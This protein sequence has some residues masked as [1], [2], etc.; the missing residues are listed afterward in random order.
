VY[1][2]IIEEVLR[3]LREWCSDEL[4]FSSIISRAFGITED[5]ALS[6]LRT[7]VISGS[8][9][10]SPLLLDDAAMAGAKGGY[11]NSAE[12]GGEWIVLN[13]T[14]LQ[15]AS[16]T[17]VKAVVL[18]EIGHA[19]D[20]RLHQSRDSPGDEGEV[21]SALI[22]GLS[23]SS[24]A[25]I[26]NDHQWILLNGS[27]VRMEASSA[28]PVNLSE[29]DR[30]GGGYI[31]NGSSAYDYSGFSVSSAGDV[32]GDGLDDLIIG[33]PSKGT[34]VGR[35][36]GNSYVVFGKSTKDPIDLSEVAAG[37]GGYVIVGQSA[38]D[39]SG[40]SV[41]GLGDVNGDGLAD[42]FVGAPFSDP[43]GGR[44]AGR[45]YVVFGQRITNTVFLS[46]VAAGSGGFVINGQSA[47]D[48]SGRSISGAGDVNGDG[49]S[50]FIVGAPFSDSTSGSQSGRSYVVFGKS[51]TD[52]IDLSAVS[53]GF[54]GFVINAERPYDYSGFSVSGAGD[55]N[56]DGFADLVV[57]SPWSRASNGLRN[58]RSYVVF[59][60]ESPTS[61]DLS[62]VSQGNGGF[63]IDGSQRFSYSGMSVSSAGDVNG[64]GL[65][66][67]LVGAQLGDTATAYNGGRTYVVFGKSSTAPLALSD[68]EAGRGGGFVVDG[69]AREDR[70][71]NSV[72]SAGDINGDGLGD[73][74]IGAFK[75]NTSRLDI[76][77]SYVVF[78]KA[79]AAPVILSSLVATNSGFII[80]GQSS[81]DYSGSSVS[82]AGDVNG[83][84]LADLAVGAFGGNPQEGWVNGKNPSTGFRAGRTYVIFGATSGAFSNTFIDRMGT[85]ESDIIIGTGASETFVGNYGDDTIVGNGGAD[86]LLG[87]SGND[88]LHLTSTNLIAL[89][90]P[91]GAGG[92]ANQLARLDG[93]AGFDT[94]VLDGS[95]LSFNLDSVANQRAAYSSYS[96]RLNSIEAFDLTGSGANSLSLGLSDIR[97]IVDFN[98][99]NSQTSL[100]LGFASGSFSLPVFQDRRQSV[101]TG[102]AGDSL[103]V[104]DGLWSNVGTL[105]GTGR[106]AGSTFE[107]WNGSTEPLQLIVNQLISSK[108]PSL[109]PLP[110]ISLAVSSAAV[111]EDGSSNL[112]YTFSRSGDTTNPL[113]VNYA[114]GGSATNGSDYALIPASLTFAAGA[115]TAT[116][117]V[118]PI[119]D[120]I[121]EPDET[122]SLSLVARDAYTIGTTGSVS[123]TIVN[124]DN[125]T[126]SINDVAIVE[127][128]LGTRL[129]VF[130]VSLS[131]AVAGGAAVAFATA[132]GTASAGSDYVANSGLLNFTG[133]AGEL[134]TIAV[135]INGDTLFEPDESF[136]LNLSSPTNGVT[137]AK[138]QGSGT[139][140]NDDVPP[141]PV[142]SLAVSSAAVTEDGSSNLIYTFSRSGDTTNPLSVNYAIGGS[143]TNGSDYALIPAS[144]TFA[145]GARTATVIVDPI[146]D[147]IVEPDETVSLSLVARDAYTIGTTGSV[148]GTIVDILPTISAS[149]IVAGSGGFVINGELKNDFFGFNVASL[150]DVNA[151]GYAD[152]IISAHLDSLASGRFG[153]RS[154]VVFG[155]NTNQAVD[156]SE[157]I[158]GRGG[159]VVNGQSGGDQAGISVAGVGDVN[160]DGFA[161]FIVGA[162]LSDPATGSN[163]GR[164]YVVFGKSFSDAIE[165]STVAAGIGGFVINGQSADDRSGISVAGAGDVNGDGLAD[166]IVGAYLSDTATG[167]NAGRSYVVFGKTSTEATSLSDVA[168]GRGGFAINGQSPADKSG[169]SVAG[170]GDVNGDGLADVIIGAHLSDPASID[171][172]G[173]SYVVFGKTSNEAI[174]LASV[175][176]GRGGLV[177]NGGSSQ[178]YSGYSI[179]SAGDVNGDGFADLI[180][181]A[182]K[183]NVL[184]LRSGRSFVVFGKTATSAID[185]SAI[186]RGGGGGF[187]INGVSSFDYSGLSVASAGDINGDGLADVI[188]GAVGRNTSVGYG[189]GRSYVVFGKVS[190]DPVNLSDMETGKGGL[191]LIIDGLRA[192][193][194]SGKSVSSAGDVN[195]DGLSDL[196]VGAASYDP[197]PD[198][199]GG[200]AYVILG[201]TSGAFTATAVDRSGTAENDTIIGTSEAETFVG[202]DGDDNIIGNGGADVLLGGNGNDRFH[203]KGSNLVALSNPFG[204]GGN[205][206]Q[207]SRV[208]GGFGFD[209]IVLDGSGLSFNVATVA[210]QSTPSTL[211]SSRLNSIE[212]FDLSGSGSN[213][214]SVGLGDLRDLVGFNWLNSTSAASLGITS[215]SFLIPANQHRRQLLVTGDVGDRFTVIDGL[216]SNIGTLNGANSFAGSRFNVWNS[217][218]GSAQLLVNSSIG[219]SFI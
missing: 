167:I 53:A 99:L 127:G 154:Y 135:T 163:A 47:G 8:F 176:A 189:A 107:V 180:V 149:T 3:D 15:T 103:I 9:I 104:K 197:T 20:Y 100:S 42:L 218:D 59:G 188:V 122:V 115:R 209:T 124:D 117:I 84:G 162:H 74:I 164:S 56:G 83:D 109:I 102:D 202:H 87:G 110:V 148:S 92:N 35:D 19:I 205:A 161:D 98:W 185:L 157:V 41:A 105:L 196:I 130:T 152:L 160:G 39:R 101:I 165:L 118:D 64:D 106:F 26:E 150:G 116:V 131:H 97:N 67:I 146:A 73:I 216:W 58:G 93:G 75:A 40:F 69:E 77:K 169:F 201:S 213:S 155:K 121:V 2:G 111:T 192:F 90:H 89:A 71:G 33:A 28:I 182:P 65:A 23:P 79:S 108:I 112:I 153:G 46:S 168:M 136:F 142:I 193:D 88:R 63:V 36:A 21:F 57:G 187:V 208:D 125:A 48:Q 212:A 94:I 55:V 81:F 166:L 183:S 4:A 184:G 6:A 140:R 123:G 132:N 96:S 191:G 170:A 61:I 18:E 214:L 27:Q 181:G 66:D 78:G 70:S 204:V 62:A 49:F 179:S 76:G 151:D 82:A 114:I 120:A 217:A 12:A 119:A 13:R 177:I 178:D 198:N 158:A 45:S 29:I 80:N 190:S 173:R 174:E 43:A 32:N 133:T 199:D 72:A 211:S 22:R 195:G 186:A 5:S 68:L 52:A 85:A 203:L 31:I 16:A 10:P 137:L 54:G 38:Q 206:S 172:A 34:V 144:L 147:A 128:D 175:A 141:L 156:I 11:V 215:G 171:N 86:V 139:I 210:N 24:E 194:Y 14:W 113:S 138:A 7:E 200:R 219:L 143:A 25:E 159:F 126:F 17:Q 207:L 129:A 50:D 37:R 91:F 44:D 134:R 51:T 60:K 30:G 1:L 95:G 145:A